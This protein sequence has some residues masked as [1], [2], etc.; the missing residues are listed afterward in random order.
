MYGDTRG[1]MRALV[2]VLLGRDRADGHLPVPVG[3]VAR[4]GC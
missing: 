4:R 2:R 3:N 1:A